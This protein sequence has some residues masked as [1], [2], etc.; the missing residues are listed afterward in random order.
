MGLKR[1]TQDCDLLLLLI[2]EVFA[3]HHGGSPSIRYSRHLQYVEGKY[4]MWG[5]LCCHNLLDEQQQG[6][7][8]FVPVQI[9][10]II[11]YQE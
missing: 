9:D 8:Y 5:R 1:L 4:P 3:F 2:C 11:N 10:E 7:Q 6:V